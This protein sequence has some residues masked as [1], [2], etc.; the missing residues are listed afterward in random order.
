[1]IKTNPKIC[2]GKGAAI[3]FK[4]CGDI[5]N[6]FRYG[7]CQKC[8][9]TWLYTTTEGKALIEKSTIKAKKQVSIE[10]KKELRDQKKEI[11]RKSEY[12]GILQSIVNA[13]VRMVDIDRGCISCSHGWNEP[14]TRQ[15]HAGHRYSRGAHPAIRFNM[16][17]IFVQCSICNNYLSGNERNFDKGILAHHGQEYLDK[18]EQIKVDYQ[19]LK[20]TIPELQE[21]IAKATEVKKQLIKGKYYGRDQINEMIGIYKK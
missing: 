11:M 2:K 6:I 15:R 21:A 3:N 9:G 5:K 12:E 10:G 14:F 17:D 19:E 7:L 16:F 20:L 8:Y 18:L 1:M 13:I 4:G